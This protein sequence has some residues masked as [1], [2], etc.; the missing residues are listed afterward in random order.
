MTT[1]TGNESANL[2]LGVDVQPMERG[3]Q[4]L[5][6]LENSYKRTRVSLD[7]LQNSLDKYRQVSEASLTSTQRQLLVLQQQAQAQAE[8]ARASKEQAAA[9]EYIASAGDKL[10]ARL[11][12]MVS[13]YGMTK[14]ELLAFRAAELGVTEAAAPHIQ[15]LQQMEEATRRYGV[16]IKNVTEIEKA[17]QQ[18]EASN[19]AALSAQ[20]TRAANE[21][22]QQMERTQTILN[23]QRIRAANDAAKEA[24]TIAERQAIEEI[25]WANTSLRQRIAIL[26]ELQQ[27]QQ[28]AAISAETTQQR[29][30]SAAIKDLPNLTRL[31]EEYKRSTED[32]REA[33]RTGASHAGTFAEALNGVSFSSARARSE[34]IVLAHEA[35]Q[36]RFTRIPASMMVLAEYTNMASLAFSGLG[37]SVIA[38]GIAAA[39]AAVQIGKGT[40]ELNEFSKSLILTNN[41]AG[42]TRDSLAEM[43]REMTTLYSP[44]GTASEMMAKLAESGKFTKEAI[45]AIGP[46]MLKFQHLT[47]Q[48]TEQ[49]V[50]YFEGMVKFHGKIFNDMQNQTADW[51]AK[52]NDSYHF[53]SAAQYEHI[54]L[55]ALEGKQQEAIIEIGKRFNENL[56][57]QEERI[58]IIV[59]S[60]RGWKMI[61][62]ETAHW[63]QELGK[64]WF[65]GKS[66]KDIVE[67]ETKKYEALYKKRMEIQRDLSFTGTYNKK[68]R[69]AAIDAEIEEQSK[70][71]VEANHKLVA[72]QEKAQK[73]ADLAR[74]NTIGVNSQ[75]EIDYL[76]AN[77]KTQAQLEQDKI[78]QAVEAAKNVNLS[79]IASWEANYK[80][81]KADMARQRELAIASGEIKVIDAKELN[82]I[83]E[84]I[85]SKHHKTMQDGRKQDL[86]DAM[87]ADK[88]KFDSAKS[89]LDNERQ[90]LEESR[91]EGVVTSDEYYAARELLRA[92]ELKSLT[93]YKDAELAVLRRYQAK[94]AND[95]AQTR[96]RIN[97][98]IR[99]FE[100]AKQKLEELGGLDKATKQKEEAKTY[101]DTILAIEALGNAENKQLQDAIDKQRIHNEQIGKSNEEKE[102]AKKLI[103]E[104][105]V[106][107]LEK[108]AVFLK[109]IIEQGN[110]DEKTIDA[111]TV[112]LS[113]MEEEIAKRKE[114]IKLVDEG[115]AKQ[116]ANDIQKAF[117]T[118]W[119]RDVKRISDDLTSA[120]VDGGGKGLQKLIRDMK[121]EFA[122]LV[123]RPIIQPI[124]EGLSSIFN[125][126][127]SQAAS[128]LSNIAG[129][130]GSTFGTNFGSSGGGGGNLLGTASNLFSI[131]KN[132]YTGFSSGLMSTMGSYIADL[133]VTFGSSALQGF[134]MGMGMSTA[135][136]SAA[137]AV[138]SGAGNAAGATGVSAGAGFA[139]AIPVIGWIISGMMASNSLYKQG[140]DFHNGS[141]NTLGKVL[142]SGINGFDKI[143]RGLGLSDST[144]NIFSGLAPVSKL[145]GRK[146]PEVT[147]SGIR[148]TLDSTG[149]KAEQYADILEK[150]GWFRSDKRYTKTAS[151]DTDFAN[152][153]ASTFTQMKAASGQ[154]AKA[155]D[156]NTDK[157]DQYSTTFKIVWDKDPSKRDQ[158]L[159]DYLGTIGDGIAQYLI[160]NMAEF[161]R[162]GESASQT[163]QRLAE[164]FVATNNIASV[165]GKTA[166]QAFGSIGLSSDKARERLVDLAGGLQNLVQSTSSYASNYLTSGEQ[167]KP[168]VDEVNKVMKDL[169]YSGVTTK[170]QFKQLVASLDLSSDAGAKAFVSLM[171]IQDAFA[172]VTD[173]VKES[174]DAATDKIKDL[175]AAA[176]ELASQGLDSALQAVR[177]NVDAEKQKADALF[178][179]QSKNLKSQLDNANGLLDTITSIFDTLSNAIKGTEI[180]S[181]SYDFARRKSAQ[182]R[183]QS[184]QGNDL[185]KVDNLDSILEDATKV[186][187]NN[188]ATFLDYAR[189][190]AKSAS[191]VTNLMNQS[192]NQKTAEQKIVDSLQRQIEI[193]EQNHDD[194]IK[195]LDEIINQAEKQAD[196]AR[197]LDTTLVGLTQALAQLSMAIATFRGVSA[198]NASGIVVNPDGTV[199]Q[200]NYN[201]AAIEQLYGAILGRK[202]DADGLKHWTQIANSGVSLNQIANDFVNSNEYRDKNPNYGSTAIS[203]LYKNL[204]G[205]EGEAQGLEH[206]NNLYNNGMSIAEITKGFLNSEEYKRL[207]PSYDIGTDFVKSDQLAN[208]H[209]G[210]RILTSMDN[211]KLTS[212]ITDVAKD[213]QSSTTAIQNLTARLEAIETNRN[214]QNL[215]MVRGIATMSKLH[216]RWETQGIP[217]RA[218]DPSKAIEV[219]STTP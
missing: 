116:L 218:V 66:N 163:L 106:L 172:K 53:L 88:A 29:F 215:A 202:S 162:T 44:I 39:A 137:S 161:A 15:A 103:E 188:Y 111:Y 3:T 187:K 140:W 105:T 196:A 30:S 94:G 168:I 59:A 177:N 210:E 169:G 151:V 43:S 75:R 31:Q 110:W 121:K 115:A 9:Q 125:P 42:L 8:L 2:T 5:D 208:I 155:L 98:V 138:A 47:G 4:A 109:G 91:K 203:D 164:T 132:L 74:L 95:A 120:I 40:L 148:G 113:K 19:N 178:E 25:K 134:G 173:A 184:L 72:E 152:A 69:L 86:A 195:R 45:E 97:D 101:K 50:G 21:A 212:T 205:R 133:G 80:G 198:G 104:E 58:G 61:I 180:E 145:F 127:A 119:R 174:V 128:F 179:A 49:V 142:G 118:E 166:E 209:R 54:R 126:N 175:N 64:D 139:N 153:V 17:R 77:N 67:E 33:H 117:D 176:L 143:L 156:V 63:L 189:D 193:L 92:K 182:A 35:V 170:E 7:D 185:S 84:G 123:L 23:A 41:Y 79:N 201:A 136:A 144:A 124:A 192:G 154:F 62:Q 200:P 206:W 100:L 135:Q 55:L 114:L 57:M 150:G 10:I 191:L 141:V 52:A 149:L 199:S 130:S 51:A 34:L 81:A 87:A 122:Q 71:L 160:P 27:Y 190:Q 14:N 207:H 158:Q 22:A 26:Q 165:L 183:L 129:S 68:E 89:A 214:A 13:T 70:K 90:I 28:S 82:A 46:A 18:W 24:A 1:P 194:E 171:N 204:L 60:F 147:E 219:S 65:N 112:R 16:V 38:G 12:D 85:Q 167:L 213:K 48:S 78:N 96:K 32:V 99:D 20:R 83:I 159:Q 11:Q 157:L 6:R 216:S 73:K 108:D 107:Q 93:E 37:V 36:G 76:K 102:R 131:G 146:N 197:G 217:V 211:R 186:D 181:R 56:N